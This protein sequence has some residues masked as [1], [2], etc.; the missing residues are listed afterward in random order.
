MISH[1]RLRCRHRTKRPQ[2]APRLGYNCAG[3]PCYRHRRC[4]RKTRPEQ[5]WY[6]PAVWWLPSPLHHH[7][8]CH[9]KTNWQWKQRR[10]GFCREGALWYHHHLCRLC[11]VPTRAYRISTMLKMQFFSPVRCGLWRLFGFG[12]VIGLGMNTTNAAG[13]IIPFSS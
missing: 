13:N 11:T 10:S 7:R 3:F 12:R 1:L 5:L 6:R 2:K 9:R 8:R 4:H